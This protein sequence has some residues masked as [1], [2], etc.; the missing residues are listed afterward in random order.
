MQL[1][2]SPFFITCS[3]LFVLH[4]ALQFAFG[5]YIP[6]AHAYLDNLLAMP[7]ILT[8]LLAERKY[9][10]KRGAHYQ[11]SFAEVMIATV[12]VSVVSEF[13]LPLLSAR[14]VYDP[15]DFIF[16]FLGMGLYL[17][18]LHGKSIRFWF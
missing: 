8:L 1:F 5:I 9:V 2:L 11:L 15:V 17:F 3:T 4:Q 18:S 12:Y 7:I 14:F 13:L 10:F 6:L 16:Y